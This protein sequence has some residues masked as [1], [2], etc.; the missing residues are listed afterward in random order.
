MDIDTAISE[1]KH[2]I[3]LELQEYFRLKKL[4]EKMNKI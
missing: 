2:M 4:L 1:I 3:L